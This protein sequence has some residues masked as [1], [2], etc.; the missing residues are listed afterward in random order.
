MN[1]ST[2][3]PRKATPLWI[4]CLVAMLCAALSTTM[5]V[6]ATAARA[7]DKADAVAA[8]VDKALADTLSTLAT[9]DGKKIAEMLSIQA[10][11]I[12]MP[13]GDGFVA[14]NAAKLQKTP[15][16]GEDFKLPAGVKVKDHEILSV[17]GLITV[18]ATLTMPGDAP[19]K[20]LSG[21]LTDEAGKLKYMMLSI[22]QPKGDK[23]PE[24]IKTTAAIKDI[25]GA[26]AAGFPKGDVSPLEEKLNED[27]FSA[28]VTGP[29]GQLF[30]FAYPDYFIGMINSFLAMGTADYSVLEGVQVDA[31][32]AVATARA[33]WNLSITAFGQVK[34][35]VVAHFCKTAKGW[36][37]V[38]MAGGVPT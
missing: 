1:D 25:L 14:V 13:K 38:G 4:A 8:T 31:D 27:P 10:S 19:D 34:G 16:L 2:L 24:A 35:K 3:R 29:D 11:E 37:L 36:R 7:D 20:I 12:L 18:R 17:G 22:S 9:A 32:G 30:A 6:G 21:V 5:F 23:D 26:W 15:K 33:N 28:A